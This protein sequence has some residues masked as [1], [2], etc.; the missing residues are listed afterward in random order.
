MHWYTL[1][2]YNWF[3]C[4]IEWLCRIYYE[5]AALCE[6]DRE[7]DITQFYE[8]LLKL[9][10][11]SETALIAKAAYLKRIGELADSRDCLKQVVLLNAQLFYA[12]LMLSQVYCK[13]YCW[14]ETENASRKALQLIKPYLKDKFQYEIKLRLLEAISK[15]SNEQKLI[16]ARQMCQEVSI[17]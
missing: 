13:L 1:V 4:A 17:I 6:N 11:N 16:E 2:R 12:W 7:F 5:E 3:L 14:E 15:S 8:L 9:K 10:A